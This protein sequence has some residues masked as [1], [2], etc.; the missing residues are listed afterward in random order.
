MIRDIPNKFLI[1]GEEVEQ[2]TSPLSQSPLWKNVSSTLGNSNWSS[3]QKQERK[4]GTREKG[5]KE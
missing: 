3:T 5:T 2:N 1:L 4:K